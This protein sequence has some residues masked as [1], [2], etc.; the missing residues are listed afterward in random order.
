MSRTLTREVTIARRAYRLDPDR[1]ERMMNGI[2][3]EPILRHYVVVD[4]RRYPPKQVIAEITGLDRADFTTHQARRI[5]M[6][7][8]FAVGRRSAPA[9]GPRKPTPA[10]EPE[11]PLAE[12]MRAFVGRWVAIAGDEVLV[13]ADS[14]H[15]VVRWLARHRRMA[16][17]MFRVPD[18]EVAAAGL[19]PL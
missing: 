12:T 3:P 9:S 1:V 5:L 17:S 11:G 19:A 7:L 10:E 2:L 13:A 18:D 4:Q 15:E 16:D 6:N 8:G 14:P